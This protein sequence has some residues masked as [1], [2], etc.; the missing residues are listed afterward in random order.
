MCTVGNEVGSFSDKI[1]E[2]E[3]VT[4]GHLVEMMVTVITNVKCA[5]KRYSLCN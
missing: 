1:Y 4:L 5:T 3:R 2:W